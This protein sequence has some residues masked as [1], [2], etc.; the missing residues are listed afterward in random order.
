[1]FLISPPNQRNCLSLQ[2]KSWWL[3]MNVIR[4][5]DPSHNMSRLRPGLF[6]YLGHP[7]SQLSFSD[8]AMSPPFVCSLSKHDCE[9]DHTD[10]QAEHSDHK[11]ESVLTSPQRKIST[12]KISMFWPAQHTSSPFKLHHRGI[13]LSSFF[14]VAI[15]EQRRL[16]FRAGLRSSVLH[17]SSWVILLELAWPRVMIWGSSVLGGAAPYIFCPSVPC[18]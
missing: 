7:S 10:L 12:N 8:P 16:P 11:A 4:S 18:M 17:Q 9:S 13:K 1:M 5:L 6:V 14:Y 3:V 2:T 15:R